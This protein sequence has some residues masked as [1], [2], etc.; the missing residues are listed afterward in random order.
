MQVG[1]S[2]YKY[3]NN[4]YV[5]DFFTHGKI[6]VGTLYEYR[7][8]EKYGTII[9]DKDEG[10]KSKYMELTKSNVTSEE[11]L[12][13]FARRIAKF[14]LG[15]GNT[16]HFKNCVFEERQDSPD[17]FI[18]SMC[19]TYDQAIMHRLDYDT[20][21]KIEQPDEFFTALS[22]SL[23]HKATFEGYFSCIYTNRR[24]K[25]NEVD[26]SRPALIK[27]PVY[28]SQCEVRAIWMPKKKTRIKHLILNCKKAVKYC[29]IY[30]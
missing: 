15:E 17:C 20:C 26:D 3:I 16:A 29:R 6:R 8:T 22:R 14:D 10:T 1:S 28:K 12:P 11:Q 2:F 21:I 9:G 23:R 25:Y 13:D 5:N 24:R 30:P 18:Y 4:K 7:N 27:D 19:N